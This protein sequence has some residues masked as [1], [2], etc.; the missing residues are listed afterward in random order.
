VRSEPERHEDDDVERHPSPS[1]AILSVTSVTTT[2][3]EIVLVGRP[4]QARQPQPAQRLPAAVTVEA[5]K[6]VDAPR[7]EAVATP[8]RRV[9]R[10]AE[11]PQAVAA[12]APPRDGTAAKSSLSP[13][14]KV[15]IG[16]IEVRA[17]V[18]PQP[19][20]QRPASKQAPTLALK[21]YLSRRRE[22]RR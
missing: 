11:P 17:V 14:I 5:E 6:T 2:P 12:T 21:D 8:A 20:A 1:R 19:P 15:H 9:D 3:H 4:V 13:T 22:G 10:R 7:V 18:S 16:R